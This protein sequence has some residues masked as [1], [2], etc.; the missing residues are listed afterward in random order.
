MQSDKRI[1]FPKSNLQFLSDVYCDI[2]I[3]LLGRDKG[4]APENSN[5]GG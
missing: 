3:A 1:K 5:A 2:L 4:E